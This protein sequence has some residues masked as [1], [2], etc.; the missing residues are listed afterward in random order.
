LSCS[1]EVL[2]GGLG[3][4]KLQFFLQ[5][6]MKN[7]QIFKILGH[8]IPGSGINEAGSETLLDDTLDSRT[9]KVVPPTVTSVNTIFSWA[10]SLERQKSGG[11]HSEISLKRLR[12]RK[13]HRA[14]I[15]L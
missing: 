1:L 6:N 4:S 3:I 2:Y 10:F 12:E 14:G 8:Q 7:L 11:Y 13:K 9:V 15:I 5:K